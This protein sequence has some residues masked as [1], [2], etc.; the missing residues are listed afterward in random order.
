MY[1]ALIIISVMLCAA[2][3]NKVYDHRAHGDKKIK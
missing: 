2:Q 3:K 1:E